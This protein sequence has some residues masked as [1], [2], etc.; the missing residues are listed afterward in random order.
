MLGAALWPRPKS[1]TPPDPADEIRKELAAGRPVTLVHTTGLPK[2]QRILLEPNAVGES[3]LGDKTC[4]IIGFGYCLLEL[5]PN[6]G[7]DRY[8]IDLE[9]RQVRAN[10]SRPDGPDTDAAGVYLGYASGPAAEGATAHSMFGITFKDYMPTGRPPKVPLTSSVSLRTMGWVQRPDKLVEDNPS[11]LAAVA[12]TPTPT[13]PG[14]W[15]AMSIHVNPAGFQVIWKE[16]GGKDIPLVLPPNA[17]AVSAYG[18]LKG[19]LDTIA[20]GAL[21]LPNW[22]P[23]M[24]LGVFSYRS[25]VSVRNVIITPLPTAQ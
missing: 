6:P 19:R 4:S 21:G 23:Q 1:A 10:M 11:R 2:Y 9:I 18:A 7:C 17:T 14:P 22:S 15:R 25:E 12:F 8:R 3:S 13:R 20:P 24:P 5:C 16:T